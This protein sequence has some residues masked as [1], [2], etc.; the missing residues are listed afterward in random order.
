MKLFCC[1][2]P[3]HEILLK[4]Y[5]LP[6]V[7]QEFKVVATKIDLQGPGDFLSTEFLRC[8]S[9]KMR[10]VVQSLEDH[11]GEVIVWSDIDIQFFDLQSAR[12]VKE[13]GDHD[14]AFQREGQRVTDINAGFVVCRANEK[15]CAFF[16]EVK[17]RLLQR[18]EVNEQFVMNELLRKNPQILSW[19]YL[20]WPYYAR[21]HGWPPPQNLALYHA[22][23]TPGKGGVD[24]K[25]RQFREVAFLRKYGWLATF[26]TCIK[27][28]PK[29]LRRILEERRKP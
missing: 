13:L 9:E 2:T 11:R 4:D 21:T 19:T 10:L 5:F 1:Y 16:E 24:Q 12:L 23:A 27:Y 25:I 29:R 3:A 18:P 14:I 20:P 6:T 22:N 28:I 15:V 17:R 26:V 8:I 7:P